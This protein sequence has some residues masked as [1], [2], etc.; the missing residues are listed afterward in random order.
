MFG[1]WRWFDGVVTVWMVRP[2]AVSGVWTVG[3]CGVATA[4]G[5]VTGDENTDVGC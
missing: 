3:W 2:A 1:V 5:A 4:D